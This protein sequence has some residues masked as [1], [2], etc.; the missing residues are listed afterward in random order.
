MRTSNLK[1]KILLA[2]SAVLLTLLCYQAVKMTSA[3]LSFYQ[4]FQLKELWLK[5]GALTDISQ[6]QTA[7]QAINYS[8]EAHKNNPHYLATQ[9][10]ILEWG[11]VSHIFSAEEQQKN[12]R[13][14]KKSYLKAV[15]LRPTWPVT[16]TTLAILKWRLNEID[17]SLVDYLKQADKFGQ[18]SLGVHR[19]WVDV[20]FYL[21]KSKSPY[22]M[23]IIKGLRRHLRLMMKD[24]RISVRRSAIAMIKRHNAEKQA[25]NWL[26]TYD[27]DTTWHKARLCKKK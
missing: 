4:T 9:G 5:N 14:A 20:G 17:Q 18:H 16:W 19:A 15:E 25:C 2:V 13:L 6:Y 8:D 1:Q 3:N 27:F 12:L 10:L 11:G 26:S 21:Y 7:L 23:Q 22:T 24:S